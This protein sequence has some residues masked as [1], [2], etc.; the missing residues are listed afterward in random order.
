MRIT[1]RPISMTSASKPHK[2]NPQHEH[3]T[4]TRSDSSFLGP[5]LPLLLGDT[6]R[7]MLIILLLATLI[8]LGPVALGAMIIPVVFLLCVSR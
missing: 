4:P 6:M 7:P 5:T 3:H 2:D 8:W 1:M